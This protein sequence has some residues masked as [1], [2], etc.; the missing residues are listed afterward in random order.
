MPLGE[1]GLCIGNGVIFFMRRRWGW[2]RIKKNDAFAIAAS[3]NV[4]N[5]RF[6]LTACFLT[7]GLLQ[8]HWHV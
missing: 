4:K 2:G 6:F 1:R 7:G 8:L 3:Y 5:W